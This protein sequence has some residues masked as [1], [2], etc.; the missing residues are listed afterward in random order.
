MQVIQLLRE[1]WQEMGELEPT[2]GYRD[3]PAP[4]YTKDIRTNLEVS[5]YNNVIINKD[6][7]E[8]NRVPEQK[9]PKL[10]RILSR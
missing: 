6:V 4:E 7:E 5:S 2:A 9:P 10:L 8:Q 3:L 1:A